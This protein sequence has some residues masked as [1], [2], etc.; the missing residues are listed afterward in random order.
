MA[1]QC[2]VR[3]GAA[4]S[5][6]GQVM[7]SHAGVGMRY[8]ANCHVR[9]GTKHVTVEVT[10]FGAVGERKKV[11]QFWLCEECER[12]N[13]KVL[14]RDPEQQQRVARLLCTVPEYVPA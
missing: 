5:G 6:G 14:A 3:H 9:E 4:L 11:S 7:C 8:C 13:R 12:L 1:G 2:R 10:V